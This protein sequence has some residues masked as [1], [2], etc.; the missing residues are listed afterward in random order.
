MLLQVRFQP[1]Q[2]SRSESEPRREMFKKDRVTKVSKAADKPR[3]LIDVT[4]KRLI[5]LIM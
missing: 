4:F 3:R 1:R 2:S 5:A